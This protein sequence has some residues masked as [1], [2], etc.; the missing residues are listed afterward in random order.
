MNAPS[1]N[2]SLTVLDDNANITQIVHE[3]WHASQ[4]L[5][6]KWDLSTDY[7]EQIEEVER[8]AHVAAAYFSL[9]YGGSEALSENVRNYVTDPERAKVLAEK[10]QMKIKIDQAKTNLTKQYSTQLAFVTFLAE[11]LQMDLELGTTLIPSYAAKNQV[12]LETTGSCPLNPTQND[13]TTSLFT[14]NNWALLKPILDEFV[15]FASNEFSEIGNRL[16]ATQLSDA[17]KEKK[18]QELLT[19]SLRTKKTEMAQQEN[20]PQALAQFWSRLCDMAILAL[21]K[22]FFELS[23]IKLAELKRDFASKNLLFL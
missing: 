22:N 16:K 9:Y 10:K 3:M 6:G 13:L 12:L 17:D 15:T 5:L 2:F 19:K 1:L 14:L 21:D 8:E 20:L 18:W 7:Y 23:F 11:T 4:Q